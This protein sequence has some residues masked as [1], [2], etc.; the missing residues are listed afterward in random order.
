MVTI[1]QLKAICPNL[2]KNADVFIP[3]LAEVATKYNINTK[4]RIAAYIAQI[5][6]ESGQ[7]RYVREIASGKAYEGRKDLGNVIQGDGV[8]YKGR[9]LIQITGRAN[10]KLVGK[11]LGI[12][13]ENN[14]QLLETP[15]YAVL[16]SGWFWDNRGLNK[17][18]DLPDTW[19]SATKKYTPFQYITYRINGG[20]N[21]YA[22]RLKYYNKALQVLK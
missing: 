2:P 21:G 20:Q 11:A 15:R 12:D 9:G 16:S 1:E 14:P 19:R 5:A 17:F 3:Y 6:H 8:K 13:F 10:Y 18:A 7:F 4:A 22:D